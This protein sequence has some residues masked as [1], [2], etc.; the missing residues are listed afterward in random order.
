MTLGEYPEKVPPELPASRWSRSVRR[1]DVGRFPTSRR[2]SGSTRRGRTWPAGLSVDDFNGDGLLDVFTSR[3]IAT[4]AR[5]CSSTAATGRSRT[6]RVAPASPTRSWP[7]TPP[8][9]TTT[10][11]ASSTCCC[12]AA[13]GRRPCRLSLLRNRGDG[14]FEDVTAA[15][16]LGAP[17]ASQAAGWADYD[18]DGFV[19]LYMAGESDRQPAPTRGTGAGSTTTT[20]TARSPTSPPRPASVNE[21]FGKGAPGATTTTT[22]TPTSTSPTCGEPNR[23][24][25]NNGDGTFTDVA[26]ELGVTEPMASFACWCWDYDNDGRLDLFVRLPRH[27]LRGH[28]RATSAGRPTASGPASTATSATR[29][30]AT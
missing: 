4:G 29:A 30:S 8:T 25:H 3:P 12:C 23:L 28:R 17:I 24:Y 1:L 19:D 26:A 9:P 27:P 22:A 7:R 16:G 2:R 21:R 10:T 14:T 6:G 20:A 13:G 15:A 18:N 5:R 11:T